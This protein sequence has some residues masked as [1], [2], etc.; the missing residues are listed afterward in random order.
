MMK[1]KWDQ[2]DQS[3]QIS[4]RQRRGLEKRIVEQIIWE[5]LSKYVKINAYYKTMK[6]FFDLACMSTCYWGLP[7]PKYESFI[8]H[9][10]GT[11]KSSHNIYS[12]YLYAVVSW[13]NLKAERSMA[14]TFDSAEKAL[15]LSLSRERNSVVPKMFNSLRKTG[16]WDVT[17]HAK[18]ENDS[19]AEISNRTLK[20]DDRHLLFVYLLKTAFW[21]QFLPAYSPCS[22]D[23][24]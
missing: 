5:S 12:H 3:P 7:K 11:L 8:I 18:P 15:I 23:V 10:R 17:T 9:N 1:W 22:D 13:F 4:V 21:G 14:V 6:V 20:L 19:G 24:W 2:S 16:D